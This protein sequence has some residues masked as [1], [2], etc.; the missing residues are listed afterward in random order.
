M[1]KGIACPQDFRMDC[2]SKTRKRKY[3]KNEI[4]AKNNT[5]KF[6]SCKCD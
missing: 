5:S 1:P 4:I 2:Q 6:I 3:N